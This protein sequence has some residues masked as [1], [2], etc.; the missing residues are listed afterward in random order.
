M[1][2]CQHW[3]VLAGVLLLAGMALAQQPPKTLLIRGGTLID[4]T[5]GAPRRN[6]SILVEKGVIQE[7]GADLKAPADA[8]VISANGKFI[9]PGLIDARVRLGPSPANQLLRAEVDVA[10]QVQSLRA[11]LEAGVT[12]A[13]L[14]QGNVQDQLFYQRAWQAN[15]LVGPRLVLAG[16]TFTAPGGHPA[17]QYTVLAFNTRQLQLREVANVDDARNMT[18][19]LAL[20]GV[21]VFEVVYDSGLSLNPYPRLAK[22]VLKEIIF[23]AHAHHCKVFCAV[24]TNAEAADALNAGADAIEGVWE[25]TLDKDTL[26]LMVKNHVSYMPVLSNQGDLINLLGPQD[27]KR[28]LNQPVVRKT[29][30]KTFRESLEM[31]GGML[32]YLRKQLTEHPDARRALKEQE[33][34]AVESVRAAQAAGVRVIVG[35]ETGDTLVFPGAA[36]DRELQLMVKA[37]LTPMQ[38][39]EAATRNTAESMGFGEELGTVEKGKLADLVILSA[40]PLENIRNLEQVD[41]VIYD[42]KLLYGE[43][44]RAALAS[45][46]PK[47]KSKEKAGVKEKHSP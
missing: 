34:R 23:D 46:E 17:E 36:V 32:D 25:E 21:Q 3:M 4:G 37:G 6:V 30:S 14:I 10:Q 15:V 18:K 31:S 12:T 11:M 5:G 35:T 41:N 42:G 9:I 27:L 39:L 38:A 43:H 20:D 7:I 40:D 29:L 44:L 2:N 16:P 1:K 33:K 28:Y 45:Q 47:K 24:S 22:D 13:R 26:A 8:E 19:D